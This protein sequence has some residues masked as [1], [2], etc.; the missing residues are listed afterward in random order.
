MVRGKLYGGLVGGLLAT[1]VA[2]CGGSTPSGPRTGSPPEMTAEQRA[3]ATGF[4]GLGLT[5]RIESG[6]S[7]DLRALIQSDYMLLS[8][9][10]LAGRSVFR[11]VFGGSGSESVLRYLDERIHY[12]IGRQSESELGHRFSLWGTELG[13]DASSGQ[14]MAS[15]LSL[16]IWVRLL[17]TPASGGIFRFDG[18]PV[19]VRDTRAGIMMFG[20]GYSPAFPDVGR[21][22]T[23]IH[24]ARHSD[25]PAG[26]PAEFLQ[27][28]DLSRLGGCGQAHVACPP[29]HPLAGLPACDAQPWGAYTMGL[30]YLA[31][32]EDSCTGCSEKM[33]AE[34]IVQAIDA[35]SRVLVDTDEMFLGKF[36]QPNMANIPQIIGG[37][38]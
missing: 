21:V 33:R 5:V 32:V 6:V 30:L 13:T 15:N 37:N 17:Q 26:L 25:C 34:A 1:L 23:L 28:L 11:S 35:A 2:G 29:T 8:Q 12:V 27:T 31:T 18:H 9:S 19:P 3:R 36:G 4:G 10:K 38:H 22:A 14:V 20:E 7:P 16:P 24:E